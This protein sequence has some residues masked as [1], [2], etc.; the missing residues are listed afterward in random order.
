MK[1]KGFMKK[2][3]KVILAV[4]IVILVVATAVST[5]FSIISFAEVKSMKREREEESKNNELEEDFENVLI[6]GQYQ[7]VSTRNISDAYI[8]GDSSSLNDEDK[9]TLEVASDILEEIITDGMSAYEKEE[10]IYKW[11]CENIS[12]EE[13]GT[14][15]VPKARGIVDRP[16]GVLQNKQAVCVGFATSFRLLAN[17]VGL[18]CI[19]M[20]DI[21]LGHSWDIVKLDDGCWYIVDC[22]MDA[23]GFSPL[24]SSFNMNDDYAGYGHDWDS[25]LY[26]VANG[27]KYN[28]IENHKIKLD[29][30]LEL[31]ENIS[32]L[33]E[34]KTYIGYFEMDNTSENDA[35]INYIMEGINMRMS[36]DN[37]YADYTTIYNED[38]IIVV[39]SYTKYD[40][41]DPDYPGMDD[42]DININY[43]DID[44]RLDEFFGAAYD[45]KY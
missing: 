18:D 26:P 30:P 39:F 4:I 6:G 29:S 20:H 2:A 1:G 23:D 11:I 32:K 10:A 41:D 44:E 15:A 25:S 45:D 19:V 43:S 40:Y 21:G 5:T 38:G 7:I 42:P 31:I 34:N 27:T 28:Y 9:K 36:D 3:S 8:L 14:V 12:H 17:M 13:N 22:Y 37:G 33:C 16:Y 24:Y 35:Y